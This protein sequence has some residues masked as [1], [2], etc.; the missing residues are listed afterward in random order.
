MMKNYDESFE[1]NHNPNWPYISDH[2]HRILIIGGSESGKRT[3]LLNLIK[4]QQT[5]IDKI[6]LNIKDPFESKYQLLI[7]R[8]V[9]IGIKKI[10]HP[11]IDP[12]SITSIKHLLI[13]HK[14]LIMS[15]KI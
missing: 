14:L 12:K 15:M 2:P 11:F 7:K 13:I 6:Y 9:K 10:K 5:D 8:R 1:I 3:E 4:Q